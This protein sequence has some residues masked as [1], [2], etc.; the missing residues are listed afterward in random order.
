MKFKIK[1]RR[2][3]DDESSSSSS[4]SSSET[5]ASIDHLLTC[6][7]LRLPMKS[8]VRFKLVSKH[9]HS[10]ITDPHFCLRRNP[11][12][13]PAVGLFLHFSNFSVSPRFQYISFS[14]NKSVTKPPFRRL[15]FTAHG[16]RIGILQSCNGLLLCCSFRAVGNPKYYVYNPTVRRFSTLPELDKRGCVWTDKHAMSLAFDPSNSP[17]Y[18]VICVRELRSSQHQFKIYSSER[19]PWRKCGE[20]FA[21]SAGIDF[22]KGVYWNGSIHWLSNEH[23][24]GND[25]L[26]FDLESEMARVFPKP[27]SLEHGNRRS[28]YYFGESCGHLY[29]VEMFGERVDTDVYEMKRDYSE[30]FVKYK[31]DI[32]CVV[33]SYPEMVRREFD[34]AERDYYVCSVFSVVRGEREEDSFLVLQIPGR[35]VRYNLGYGSFETMHEFKGA[36]VEVMERSLR[37]WETNGFQHIESLCCI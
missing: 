29:Y 37:Y 25:P 12:P 7:L 3:T 11:N 26:C 30:W 1:F 28:N 34:V 20:P 10:L 36:E 6:I 19:G 13:N 27:P 18:K 2:T 4:S 14:P 33:A 31:V 21:A 32:S 5:V 16:S 35:V 24:D 15:N 8:L 9:W 23:G 22:G 17:H